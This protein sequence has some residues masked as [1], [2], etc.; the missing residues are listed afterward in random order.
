MYSYNSN[1]I[2]IEHI[3]EE[4]LSN[5]F[6]INSSIEF[7]FVH[8]CHFPFKVLLN[9]CQAGYQITQQRQPL[10][11]DGA[12]KFRVF[13]PGVHRE[14]YVKS[15]KIKQIQLEQDSGKSLHDDLLKKYV[16]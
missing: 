1:K 4:I 16:N 15:S 8:F 12:L 10:A 9:C 5:D 6:P 2:T 14:P 3:Y 13:T 7:H 11:V